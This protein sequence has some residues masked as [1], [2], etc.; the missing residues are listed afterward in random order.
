MADAGPSVVADNGTVVES[1]G[2]YLTF[3]GDPDRRYM[4]AKVLRIGDPPPVAAPG[5]T[6][7]PDLWV[8]VYRRRWTAPPAKPSGAS[9]V[10]R[11]SVG[12]FLA[13]GPPEFP[14]RIGT[15]AVTAADRAA[16]AATG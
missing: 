15:E 2:V 3:S 4:L 8:R 14:I 16:T 7:S 13:W 11:I 5:L 10:V 12:V 9:V 1:G 6:P